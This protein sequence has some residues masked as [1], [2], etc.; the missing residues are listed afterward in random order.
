MNNIYING[1]GNVSP[2]ATTDNR[3]FLEN[4]LSFEVRR[5]KCIDPDYKRFIPAEQ[6]RR[7]GR[8][9]R[10]GIAA[11]K[12]CLEDAGF[13]A[14]AVSAGEFVPDA[15][16]TGTGLGCVEE[17]E[18]FLT[19]MIR[20]K[21]EFLTP[22][23][24]IQSTHNTVAGQIALM[25]KCHGYNF[26]YVHRGVS[27]ESALTDAMTQMQLGEISNALVG[28]SDELTANSF[29]ITSRLGLWKQNP[30]NTFN[31]L[32]DHQRGSVAGEGSAFFFLEDHQTACS[33]AI[34]NGV[35]MFLNPS[36]PQ[37][38]SSR[39]RDFLAVHQLNPGDIDLV[40][41]GLNG[42][43]RTDILYHDLVESDFPLTSLGYFK[44][45]SGEYHTASAFATWL[46]AMMLKTQTV[47]EVIQINKPPARLEKVLIYNHFQGKNHAFILLSRP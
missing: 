29:A 13:G 1:S 33:Q 21:E 43:P 2:Q 22:T 14:A 7:M 28:G 44:N 15:I 38:I 35:T 5:L 3:H 42:D 8:I 12:L 17:T 4:P 30:V 40:L 46:A 47:P 18:K 32:N 27:F 37:E 45:L 19:S 25:L 23:A 24:F 10:M 11:S 34:L 36:S 31:L 9:I 39:V 6:I 26:T 41:M 20:N 16:I